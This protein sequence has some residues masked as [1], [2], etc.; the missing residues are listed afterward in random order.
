MKNLGLML[1]V[2]ISEGHQKKHR[3]TSKNQGHAVR[4]RISGFTMVYQSPAASPVIS[5]SGLVLGPWALLHFVLWFPL[6]KVLADELAQ[7]V[8]IGLTLSTKTLSLGIELTGPLVRA[9][10]SCKWNW[11]SFSSF[12]L[13]GSNVRRKLLIGGCNCDYQSRQTMP[14]QSIGSICRGP[15]PIQL[16]SVFG[17]LPP[18]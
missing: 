3:K 18:S 16:F 12:C 6:L 11:S 1:A 8:L 10:Q 2:M 15:H 9:C 17:Q 14:S 13:S 7:A 5:Q 4:C